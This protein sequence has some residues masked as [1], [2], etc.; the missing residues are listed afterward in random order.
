MSRESNRKRRGHGA[1]ASF[2]C[3]HCRRDVLQEAHG[4][5]HRNHCPF[6]LWSRH[7]DDAPG[8]RRARCGAAMEPIGVW[9]KRDG[10]WAV[11][12]RCTQCGAIH[13]NR[14]AG[15]DNEWALMSLAARPLAQ[16]PWPI[17]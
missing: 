13:P 16:P 3:G 5:R 6:C 14:I 1:P 8:D 12:H 4:T 15:D 2:R 11:I 9:V 17:D 7:V 10:E